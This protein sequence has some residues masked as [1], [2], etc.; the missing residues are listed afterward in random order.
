MPGYEHC[1]D[2]YSC[3]QR[4]RL[5]SHDDRS[6]YESEAAGHDQRGSVELAASCRRAHERHRLW[7]A[8]W[9]SLTRRTV[10][11]TSSPGGECRSRTGFRVCRP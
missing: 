3:G 9:C 6:A 1:A 10:I 5:S 4:C 8:G 7:T 11:R 2:G